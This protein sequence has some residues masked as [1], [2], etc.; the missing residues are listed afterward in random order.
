MNS[1][2]SSSDRQASPWPRFAQLLAGTALGL[3]AAI[4]ALAFL[5]D[6]Y[7]TGRPGLISKPGLRPQGPRT[8]AASRG[9]DP[10]F[11]AAIL[12]NSHV[13]LLSPAR[14]GPQ[15][16]AR[17]VSLT[18]PGTGPK[19]QLHLLDWFMRHRSEAPKALVFG[20][21]SKW[22][23]SDPALANDRPFPFWLYE[24]S[25]FAYAA[26][27][28]R[29]DILEELPRR[30]GYLA[31]SAPERAAPDGYWDYAA[32]FRQGTNEDGPRRGVFLGRYQPDM[33]PNITGQF[34]AAAQLS[35]ALA[36]LPEATRVILV[37]PPAYVT[38]LP[39]PGSAEEAASKACKAAFAAVARQRPGTAVI[40]W[41]QNMPD[42]RDPALWFDHTHYDQPLAVKIEASI[43]A[44]LQSLE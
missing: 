14:L 12:G 29:Y 30:I 43:A 44:T 33:P 18:V 27:L 6:P 5:L 15:T 7:D 16:R 36:T 17:F 22:C 2:I 19:E 25:G 24:R 4:L 21:D 31:R 1:S 34:P 40:D 10:A 3:G 23:V 13:Q 41:Q 11:N 9:R 28:L 37:H 26:G 35:S 39:V 38:A 32:G 8:A 42:A 20:I